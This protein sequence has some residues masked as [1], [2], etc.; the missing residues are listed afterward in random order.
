MKQVE[1]V[2][3]VIVNSGRVLCVK[4]DRN[5]YLYISKNGP[6]DGRGGSGTLVSQTTARPSTRFV[7]TG[8]RQSRENKYSDRY[9]WKAGD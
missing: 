3:A 4:R 8:W 6:F 1:V 2:A 5:T 7:T 9:A